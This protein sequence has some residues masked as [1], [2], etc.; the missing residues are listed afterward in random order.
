M[1]G[2]KANGNVGAG[3][4]EHEGVTMLQVRVKD[5]DLEK[6]KTT[7]P[8]ARPVGQGAP[9]AQLGPAS[10]YPLLLQFSFAAA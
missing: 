2:R 1:K 9:D 8:T 4:G 10:P 6:T 3:V 7:V 5:P